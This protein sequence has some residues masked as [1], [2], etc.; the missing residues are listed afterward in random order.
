M[1]IK[2]EFPLT[3]NDM[4]N[5]H[6]EQMSSTKDTDMKKHQL[7]ELIFSLERNIR[8]QQSILERMKQLYYYG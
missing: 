1:E 7:G 4:D 8:E 5:I 2:M 3:S 6:I